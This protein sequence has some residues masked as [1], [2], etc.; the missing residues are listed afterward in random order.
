MS[1]DVIA[2]VLIGLSSSAHCVFMCGGISASF[3]VKMGAGTGA[4]FPPWILTAVFHFG[5]LLSYAVIGLLLG[6]LVGAADS[7]ID[8]GPW[9]R[10]VAGVFLILMGL[11]LAN[12][13]RGLS[14]FERLMIPVWKPISAY[15]KQFIPARKPGHALIIGLFWGWLP[16]GLIYSTLAW[17]STTATQPLEAALLMFCMGLGTVPALLGISFFSQLLRTSWTGIISGVALCLFGLWTLAMPVMAVF[18]G[19]HGGTEQQMHG[20]MHETEHSQQ[21]DLHQEMHE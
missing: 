12:I 9:L 8:I 17:A 20:Q 3:S 7:L 1:A 2:A 19:S 6:V 11:Y 14:Y 18:M 13:W 16:C 15:L 4:S 10:M 21:F 5:R